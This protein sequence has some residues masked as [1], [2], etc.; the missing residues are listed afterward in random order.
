MSNLLLAA[1]AMAAIAILVIVLHK[2]RMV[3]LATYAM[4]SD[5]AAIRQETESLF[6]Q[7]QALATLEHKLGLSK[8]LPRLRRWAGSPD[9]LVVVA[10]E[11]EA[12]RPHVIMECSSGA[13]TVVCARMLQ[14]VGAGH[15]YSLE[16]DEAFASATERMLIAYGVADRATVIRAPLNTTQT[17]TPWYSLEAV[18][19]DLPPID[20]LVIDGPPAPVGKLARYPALP[21]LAPRLAPTASIL[22]DDADRD[23]EREMLRKW[24]GEFPAF[25]LSRV[26]CEKG[27]AILQR[28]S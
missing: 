22:V 1:A 14:L 5:I 3:H 23:D 26:D 15:V 28:H 20:L 25:A 12:K 11:I 27:C 4:R 24:Q 8:P 17:Q 16:H 10:N 13:S 9:F 7:L 19:R 21:M 18:P 6:E 2:I